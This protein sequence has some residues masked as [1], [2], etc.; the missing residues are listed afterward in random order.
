M[1]ARIKRWA[2]AATLLAGA[3]ASAQA[4][5]ASVES[6][7]I[8]V[9]RTAG[10]NDRQIRVVKVKTYPDGESLAEVKD[11]QSG[12]EF[13]L[14][15][16]VLTKLP[17][18]DAAPVAHAPATPAAKLQPAIAPAIQV[19]PVAILQPAQV[20]KSEERIIKVLPAPIPSPQVK[21]DPWRSAG[22]KR[23][24]Q[25]ESKPKA[26]DPWHKSLTPFDVDRP[27]TEI[28]RNESPLFPMRGA[29]LETQVP[30][31]AI[32]RA[33][34]EEPTT[35]VAHVQL[36]PQVNEERT[37]IPAGYAN[38]R[39]RRTL[40]EQMFE[41]TKGYIHEL[42]TAIRPTLR[43]DAATGLAEGS[44]GWRPEVK[45]VL[46]RA[47]SADPAPSVRAHCIALLSKLGYTDPDYIDFLRAS[48]DSSNPSMKTASAEAL[49]KLQ[50]K[51]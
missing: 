29:V 27:R 34:A 24:S 7:P 43:Q 1:N 6:G 40:A 47:A 30:A 36:R 13:T 51:R 37:V 10:Q 39:G 50:P 32:V 46:A 15:G 44:F 17:K 18:L 9:I 41:E 38:E 33:Q 35:G 23:Q 26:A 48:A 4:P 12:Q 14:P 11:V 20:V 25:I 31:G 16:K 5:S 21:P 19:A 3:G 2:L 8:L 28:A 45:Q 22:E 49:K 42:S